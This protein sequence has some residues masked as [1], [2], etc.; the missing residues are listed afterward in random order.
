MVAAGIGAILAIVVAFTS[1]PFTPPKYN[2]GFA[3][4]GFV[5]ALTFIYVIADEIVGT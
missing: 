2:A 5:V 4:L 3:A 1:V